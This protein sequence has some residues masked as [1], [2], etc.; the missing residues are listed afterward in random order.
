MA[1]RIPPVVAVFSGTDMHI[2]RLGTDIHIPIPYADI[3][4]TDI[5][6]PSRAASWRNGSKGYSG[7]GIVFRLESISCFGCFA[8]LHGTLMRMLAS[9]CI[10]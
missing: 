7:M 10:P 1:A 5:Q 4:Y 3:P 2:P 8:C 6:I 9:Y